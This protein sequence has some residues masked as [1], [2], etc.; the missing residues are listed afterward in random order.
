MLFTREHIDELMS[1]LA[2]L[3]GL[4]EE[5]I[6]RCAFLIENGRYDEAVGQA[7]IVLEEHIRELMGVHR[8]TG[9]QLVQRL[10]SSKNTE[11]TDRLRL[12]PPEINGLGNIFA[13]SFA[14]FRNRAAHTTAGYTRDEARAIIQLV[15][16]LLLTV[17]QMR[18][19]PAEHVQPEVAEILDPGAVQRL[20]RFL[21]SL[22]DIG[23]VKEEGSSQDAYKA[24]LLYRFREW[25]EHRPHL[26]TVLYLTKG[27]EPSLRF[28]MD[29]MSLVKGLDQEALQRRLL[30]AGCTLAKR[31]TTP[32]ELALTRRNDQATLDRLFGILQELIRRHRVT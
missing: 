14:A 20:Q 17:D 13:G 30:D 22:Q 2:D 23:F 11:Y 26:V 16:L 32:V 24:M 15:N 18:S 28:R 19:V 10:F 1:V 6:D 7:F 29:M 12:P 9:G 4:D 8:G 3:S 31:K 27:T 25:D 21:A 5:L